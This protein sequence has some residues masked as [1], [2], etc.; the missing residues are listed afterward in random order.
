[1]KAPALISGLFLHNHAGCII[2]II[3]I[4]LFPL[5]LPGQN[6]GIGTDNP[7][8]KLQVAGKIF[9]SSDGFQ[10]PDGSVQTRA[11]N[12]YEPQD[13]ADD[14]WIMILDMQ[15]PFIPGSFSFD[16]LVNKIKA[17][18]YQWGMT[19]TGGAGGGGSPEITNETLKII[20]NIDGSTNPLLQ[21]AINGQFIQ[22]FWLYFFR[23]MPGGGVQLYYKI[24][25]RNSLIRSFHQNGMFIGGEH[26]SHLDLIEFEFEEATWFYQDSVYTN[27]VQLSIIPVIK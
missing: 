24:R 7:T 18:D 5:F 25:V 17:L 20:K 3:G 26:Y 16:T 13:A 21:I 9:S 22:R 15:N 11:Y 2:S 4:I 8:E 6:I 1:M 27:E 12:A 10:F 14:R 23:H 19:V